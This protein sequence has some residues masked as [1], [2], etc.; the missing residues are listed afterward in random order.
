MR[1][2]MPN[3][4][5]DEQPYIGGVTVVHIEDL[6]IAR[7]LSRRPASACPHRS[8]VYDQKERRI[9]CKDCET[10][11]EPFDAFRM[12]AERSHAHSEHLRDREKRVKEAEAF[13]IR[14]RAAKVMDEAWRSRNMVPNCPHCRRG[15]FPEDVVRG[16]SMTGR[17]YAARLNAKKP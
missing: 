4:P 3:P 16:V 13:Q 5:I 11:V 9:W 6:R 10:D 7:G 8:L 2:K 17:D 1:G 14:S 15:I 12:L